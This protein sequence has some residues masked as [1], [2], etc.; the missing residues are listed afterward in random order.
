[1]GFFRDGDRLHGRPAIPL[2][3]ASRTSGGNTRPFPTDGHST[4]G[5]TLR[6]VSVSGIGASLTVTVQ[7]SADE[8]TWRDHTSFSAMDA[9]GSQRLI[10]SALDHFWRVSWTLSGT[11]EFDL[12][13]FLR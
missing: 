6:V 1:M 8:A 3:V 2:P 11:F 7:H 4:L 13:G 9:A 5:L 10:I 12:R